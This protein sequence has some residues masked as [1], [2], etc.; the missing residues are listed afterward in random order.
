MPNYALL[1]LLTIFILP[2]QKTRGE[3]MSKVL[4]FSKKKVAIVS[5]PTDGGRL[6]DS[7]INSFTEQLTSTGMPIE[8]TNYGWLFSDDPEKLVERFSVDKPDI[9]FLPDDLI[10]KKIAPIVEKKLPD[11]MVLFT[12]FYLKKEATHLV[13]K[14][15][16]VHCDAPIEH[17]IKQANKFSK[18]K[19]IGIVGGPFST[20]IL[21]TVTSKLKKIDVTFEHKLTNR[22]SE[23]T[24][25]VFSFAK[26][27][28][29]VWAFPPF[30]VK[31]DDNSSIGNHQFNSL[32]KEIDKPSLGYGGLNGIVRTMHMDIDPV[33]VGRNA[34]S[35]AFKYFRGEN[36][37][38]Q[39]FTSYGIRIS[40]EHLK[41]LKL[42]VP[43]ELLGFITM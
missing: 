36:V 34:A 43:S 17:L 15:I 42:S 5:F 12:A 29:A 6:T 32:L 26:K 7:T 30:G 38:V 18:I 31:S 40:D 2:I 11:T 9:V 39:E 22:W 28:D 1:V 10:Y 27:Y 35:M 20:E 3:N 37:G 25:T 33:D 14:Q 21:D 19:S 4:E 13:R 23:Y 8:F 24:E 16:G 41:R